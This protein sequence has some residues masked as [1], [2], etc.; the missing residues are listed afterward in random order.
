MNVNQFPSSLCYGTHHWNPP[1]SFEK[2]K[3]WQCGGLD[4][5]LTEIIIPIQPSEEEE[6]KVGSITHAPFK[7]VQFSNDSI[8]NLLGGAVSTKIF[9][10]V[11]ALQYHTLN[12]SLKPISE[13]RKLKMPQHH[14]WWEQQSNWISLLLLH[15]F[16]LSHISCWSPLLKDSMISPD[17]A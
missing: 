15:N 1:S 12:S 4:V 11:R 13:W 16:F 14:G 3:K 5:K 17:I 8:H 7:L 6:S 10:S 9:S 2:K